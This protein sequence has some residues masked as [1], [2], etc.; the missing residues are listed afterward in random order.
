VRLT[1]TLPGAGFEAALFRS[2]LA[3][4]VY[5]GA[6]IQTGLAGAGTTVAGL[7]NGTTQFFGLGV[8]PAGGGAYAPA[9]VVLRARPGAPIYVDA[10]AAA[11]G[12]NGGTPG[13]AFPTLAAGLAAANAAGGANVWLREGTY[14]GSLLPLG[15]DVHV[16]GGF[17]AAFDLAT[18]DPAG[19][20]TVVQGPG[21]AILLDVRDSVPSAVVDGIVLDGRGL[22]AIGV[23]VSEGEL[24][25]RSCT[26]TDF[27]DRGIRLRNTAALEELDV[28]IASCRV[29]RNGADGL[30]LLGPFD[31]RVDGSAFDS[32]VQ[33]GIELDDLVA[34]AGDTA[35]LRVEGSRF[36]GNGTEGLDAD[37]GL[38][39]PVT[40]AGDFDVDVRGCR[41]ERNGLDGCLIDHDFES[42]PG[43]SA[44]ILIRECI[45]R[46]NLQAGFHVD[47]DGPGGVTFHRDLASANGSDGFAL[48][49]ETLG[50][51]AVA[52]VCVA[53]GNG[54]AGMRCRTGNRTLAVSHGIVA[55]NRSVGVAG[56]TVATIPVEN[57]AN[58]TIAH[59]QDVPFFLTRTQSVVVVTDPAVGVFENA[60]EL[61][62]LATA[63]AGTEVTLAGAPLVDLGVP[64]ELA[65]DG[66]RFVTQAQ[67]AAV[68]S[69][70][71]AP[72]ATA[73]A[74][75]TA[76]A[77]APGSVD[78]DWALPIGS[79]ALGAGMIPPG[80]A[81]ADAGPLGAPDAG[82]PGR[83][84][85]VGVEPFRPVSV[86]PIP[87]TLVANDATL[88]LFFD[89]PIAPGSVVTGV[90]QVVRQ[91]GALVTVG[92][93]TS[94][95][96]LDVLPP[97]GGWGGEPF[98]LLLHRGITAQ[99]GTPLA[100]PVVVPF[101]R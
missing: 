44:S 83:P 47:A 15:P 8:R 73:P 58:S 64:A 27:A 7:P 14:P 79:P 55:G 78:E 12:A 9:G 67:N 52:S 72:T 69:L 33:E 43:Y 57:T 99:D 37:L 28:Q 31:L 84:A 22:S 5:A 25:L 82:V 29:A 40:G 70:D 54:V 38:P 48:G 23:D 21:G 41:F 81:P 18:R 32:N 20:G 94:G 16:Y 4:N 91:G 85:A 74:L 30:S 36:F 46:G 77:P 39:V 45:A 49:S 86:S 68:V 60:P 34:L 98:N 80:D 61:Y 26:V 87:S 51:L 88:Q 63:I 19:A 56:P 59:L 10:A 100:A 75:F 3:A 97:G 24:E 42:A 35:T 2:T 96:R 53:M 17:G 89:R 62:A 76:F 95:E 13:T 93:S 65:D 11:G 92:L 1:W 6:P 101:F 66:T 90:V 71:V 50:G